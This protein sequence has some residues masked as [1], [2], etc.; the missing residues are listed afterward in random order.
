MQ[1]SANFVHDVREE[2][3]DRSRC[4]DDRLGDR[5]GS[6]RR[7]IVFVSD[8]RRSVRS[9][10][11]CQ[12]AHRPRSEIRRK[13]ERYVAHGAVVNELVEIAIFPSSVRRGD[14]TSRKY[15][16]ATSDG[17][18]GVVDLPKC[19]GMRVCI[20]LTTP[21]YTASVASRHFLTGAATPP[22]E[23]GTILLIRKR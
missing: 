9:D 16:E 18:D 13:V 20:C 14:A 21:S 4:S 6:R 3:A 2:R 15:R 19:F 5:S 11:H 17:A 23:E 10:S 1:S 8:G 7:E 12:R 22:H